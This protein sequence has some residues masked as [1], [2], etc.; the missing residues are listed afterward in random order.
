VFLELVHCGELLGMLEDVVDESKPRLLSDEV[1]E[2][3]WY[4]VVTVTQ[5]IVQIQVF[6]RIH[7]CSLFWSK[8]LIEEP[9]G[10]DRTLRLWW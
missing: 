6:N 4:R 3:L 9:E 7:Q 8:L 10:Q 2:F 1:D 5:A